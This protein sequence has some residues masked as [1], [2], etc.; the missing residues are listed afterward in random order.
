LSPSASESASISPSASASPGPGFVVFSK[1][2]YASLPVDDTDLTNIYTEQQIIDVSTEDDIYVCQEATNKYDIHQFKNWNDS[3]IN[4][5]L[6]SRLA[7]SLA[8]SISTVYLQIYNRN[9]TLWETVDS[10]NT[11][12]ANTKFTLTAI[13][14][15]LTNYKDINNVTAC[16]IYQLIV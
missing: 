6:K 12:A 16:R 7:C 14:S 3:E 13:I 2:Y 1:G 8:P 15:D 9:S 11:A 4:C 10:N 5:K